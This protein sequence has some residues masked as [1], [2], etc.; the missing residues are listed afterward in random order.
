M[1]N[2]EAIKNYS[3]IKTLTANMIADLA[4]LETEVDNLKKLISHYTNVDDI[5][6][7]SYI[8]PSVYSLND[9]YKD[10]IEKYK[11][12]CDLSGFNPESL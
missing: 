1:N 3:E 11:Y 7:A 2:S 5:K 12:I 4:L 8:E 10:F 6:V 9:R